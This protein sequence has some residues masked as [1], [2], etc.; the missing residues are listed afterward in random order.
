[1]TPFLRLPL[2]RIRNLL[3]RHRRGEVKAEKLP[4]KRVYVLV[5]I[6]AIWGI[7]IGARL[8]GLQ[9]AESKYIEGRDQQQRVL[10]TPRHGAILDRNGNDL[11]ST[12]R[13]PVRTS[14]SEGPA[15]GPRYSR[16][17]RRLFPAFKQF[18]L[19]IVRL[20][21]RKSTTSGIRGPARRLTQ[22]V[23]GFYRSVII[24]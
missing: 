11:R 23:S 12:W 5:A 2:S 19:R 14:T 16:P 21:K 24:S 6:M 13:T 8:Y 7:G 9:I 4:A 3:L 15:G 20:V 1:M 18:D 22:R 10:A 17:D